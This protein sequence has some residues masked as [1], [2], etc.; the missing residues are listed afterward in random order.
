MPEV[1]LPWEAADSGDGNDSST[2][3]ANLVDM[4][5]EGEEVDIMEELDAPDKLTTYC[6]VLPNPVLLSPCLW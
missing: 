2:H 4:H 3:D 6:L 1:L 5:Q